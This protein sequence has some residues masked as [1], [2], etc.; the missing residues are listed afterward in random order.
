MK[1]FIVLAA[2]VAAA[3]SVMVATALAAPAPKT[4]GDIG[5]TAYSTVQRHLT[6]NAIQANTNTCGTFWNVTNTSQFTFRLTGNTTD[7]THHVSL[8]QNGQ[9]VGGSGGYP[10]TGGDAFHWN[11]T[12][13]SLV[14]SALNLTAVYDVGAPG[15]TMHISGTVNADGS[16]SGT[17]DDNYGGSRTGTFTSPAGSATATV[18]Y[19]GKGT[20]YYSDAS[21][22]WY[23]VN[24]STVSVS[25]ADA[26]FAGPVV[27]SNFGAE[28]G[29]WLFAKV[30]DGGEPG[31]LVDAASGSFTD[32][33]TATSG[34]AG[35]LSPG[36]G[37][38]SITSG[39]LQVH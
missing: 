5:Y 28:N 29:N 1:R 11:I 24:V 12:S 23:L 37:P 10:L 32:Q 21:G 38:F 35:H 18:S 15:T 27:A 2:L 33:A 20:A 8:T 31:Y 14:G 34:V 16:I 13:G 25:G 30:H 4:T 17:W 6:F 3:L 9:T 39:N 7:Y 22:L 36:D 19:C 26:W